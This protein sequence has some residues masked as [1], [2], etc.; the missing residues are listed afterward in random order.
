MKGSPENVDCWS[1]KER[2]RARETAK[3]ARETELE[4]RRGNGGV[5]YACRVKRQQ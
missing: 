1:E 3:G 2:E 5:K 4:K